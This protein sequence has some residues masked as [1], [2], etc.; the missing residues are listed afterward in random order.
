[1][2]L[3]DIMNKIDE[4]IKKNPWNKREW[5]EKQIERNVQK[6]GIFLKVYY[7]GGTVHRK[8][9]K[10]KMLYSTSSQNTNE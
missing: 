10:E 2:L 6:I 4:I 3:G 8:T 5:I 9:I 1:M 7:I